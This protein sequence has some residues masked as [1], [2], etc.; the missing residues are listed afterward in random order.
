M[1][2]QVNYINV[3]LHG[4]EYTSHVAKLLGLTE[5]KLEK[6]NWK[7]TID[8]EWGKPTGYTIELS[9][10]S[11][12]DI[13]STIPRLEYNRV[14]VYI[15]DIEAIFHDV[16][17][18]FNAI[19]ES[20]T[21]L[22]TFV[23]ELNKLKE[24][25][26]LQSEG[27]KLKKILNRQIFIGI[28]G[29]MEV[30]LSDT[31]MN[32]V[33]DNPTYYQNFISTHPEFKNRKFELREIFEQQRQLET[34]VKKIILDTLYHNLPT[35]SNMYRDTLKIEFPEFRSISKHVFIR[36]DLVHRNGKTKEG[37]EVDISDSQIDEVIKDVNEFITS[38]CAKLNIE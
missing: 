14:N 19:T 13:L 35:V 25:S 24:L 9:N 33:F 29:T 31:F 27:D 5:E 17:Q 37:I 10:N 16:E 15:G 4:K 21:G 34:I 2:E 3:L 7:I 32:L 20:K 23:E 26:L 38:L 11:P 36:H 8:D 30:F 12:E 22:K 1:S 28:I 18:Q 6:I